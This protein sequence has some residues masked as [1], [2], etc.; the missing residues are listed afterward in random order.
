MWGFTRHIRGRDNKSRSGSALVKWFHANSTARSP[1]YREMN[2]YELKGSVRTLE[3]RRQSNVEKERS[4]VSLDHLS[5]DIE[6]SFTGRILQKT[7]YTYGANVH[8][9][10]RY[11]YDGS[12]RLMRTEELDSAGNGAGSSEFAYSE[13]TREWVNRDATE[14]IA[15][16]GI[17]EYDG[18]NWVSLSTFDGHGRLKTSKTF[19][20]SDKTLTKS[21]S[22]YLLP[23][24]RVNEYW[25]TKYGPLG[26]IHHTYGLNGDSAPLGDGRYSYE[27]TENG[28]VGKI[29]TFNEFKPDEPASSV[30][31]YEYL[32]DE[33]GNWIER[34][35]FHILRDGS[36]RS[37]RITTRRLEYY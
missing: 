29:W 30:T 1:R 27:Y 37:K 36:W 16:R 5:F 12:G 17:E 9:S 19:E 10:T 11:E 22:Q 24:G 35:A 14:V 31:I 26:R 13:S 25:I 2:E 33:I 8:R 32:D 7:S 34:R 28:R 15:S 3:Q 6:F 23:D 21:I 20:Y 4:Q 18:K